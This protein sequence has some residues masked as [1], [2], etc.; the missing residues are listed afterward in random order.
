MQELAPQSTFQKGKRGKAKQADQSLHV[1]F[2]DPEVLTPT[3]PHHHHH[4]SH[5]IR[6]KVDLPRWLSNNQDDPAL[7]VR[8]QIG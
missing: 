1:P 8:F 7:E 3:P 5:D 2:M 4:M 6:N